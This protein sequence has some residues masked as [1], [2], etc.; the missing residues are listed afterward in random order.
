MR[1]SNW[2]R[3]R[4]VTTGRCMLLSMGFAAIASLTSGCGVTLMEK[5]NQSAPFRLSEAIPP[6]KLDSSA[7]LVIYDGND[8]PSEAEADQVRGAVSRLFAT[9]YGQRGVTP[10]RFRLRVQVD[11]KWWPAVVCI[12]T[13]IFGCPTGYANANVTLDL[14]VG[15]KIFV[16]HGQATGVGGL[17]YNHL[18]GVD[19]AVG[20]AIGNA[21]ASLFPL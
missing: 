12:D 16:G 14:Q 2:L 11:Y 20:E 18:T 17:Y 4:W 13:Q 10:A 3:P 6:F 9:R 19:S 7:S 1:I 5:L 15:D 21:T 8:S